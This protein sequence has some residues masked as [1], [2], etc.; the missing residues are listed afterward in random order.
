MSI[1]GTIVGGIKMLLSGKSSE[2]NT[3]NTYHYEPDKVRIAQ[4]EADTRLRL[5]DKEAERIELMRNAQLDLIKAQA[6]SQMAID[7]A[8]IRQMPLITEQLILLQEKMT[9][10]AQKRI[11]LIEV[12]ALPIIK[13]IESFYKEIEDDINDRADEYNSKKLPQL[14][15]ML[16]Q[17]QEGSTQHNL[18]AQQISAD[19]VRQLDYTRQQ[20]EKIN[21][22][23]TAVIS[24]FLNTKE[25]ILVQ[26]GQITA[27]VINEY[28]NN[29]MPSNTQLIGNNSPVAM[30]DNSNNRED[31]L[32]D[33]KQLPV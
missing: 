19:M 24:S 23:Q 16:G 27:N 5:A 31:L 33:I 28:L 6:M 7:E 20:L 3:T 13:E 2:K 29:A 10:V 15:N 12:G 17:F 14:L 11:E 26:T 21:Q 25:K 4:I 1:I 9:E 22:R 32:E 30:L 8:R 18:F